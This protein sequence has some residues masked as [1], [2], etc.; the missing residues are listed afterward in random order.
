[1]N[2]EG[3]FLDVNSIETNPETKA[4]LTR[5][6]GPGEGVWKKQTNF[7][8]P[9]IVFGC[10]KSR[11][12]PTLISM[13]GFVSAKQTRRVNKLSHLQW[14]WERGVADRQTNSLVDGLS[15]FEGL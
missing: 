3:L 8:F 4:S 15:L 7:V 12:K 5:H 14:L 2:S 1:M 9:P 10:E 6:A 11:P 13:I